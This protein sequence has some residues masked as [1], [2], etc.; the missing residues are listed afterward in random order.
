MKNAELDAL[1]TA[2]ALMNRF[3]CDSEITERGDMK[4]LQR[5]YPDM[6]K[7]LLAQIEKLGRVI[8]SGINDADA[9]KDRLLVLATKHCPRDHHD[10]QEIMRIA[11]DERDG[12]FYGHEKVTAP[13]Y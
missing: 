12:E 2:R 4:I 6:M 1:V 5:K 9:D 10:W 8:A 7:D 13:N 11:G 3:Y